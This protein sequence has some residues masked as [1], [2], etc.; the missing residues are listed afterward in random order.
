MIF[1]Q[2]EWS[3]NRFADKIG[4]HEIYVT[5]KETCV[6][7]NVLR[8]M[9]HRVEVPELFSQQ[10]EADTR[11]F[12][13]ANHAA[14]N[15]HSKIIIR[16]TDTDVQVLACFYQSI[17][18]ADMY[19]HK[20]TGTGKHILCINDLT[21]SLGPEVCNILPGIHALTG[22]DSV[23]AFHGHGKKICH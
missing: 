2:S 21:T 14:Q 17:I 7:I 20:G 16:S 8:G 10:E 3:K 5:A 11:I 6:R 22:C 9:V 19:L 23:S 1:L 12:L 15:G 4:C 13:H 18:M